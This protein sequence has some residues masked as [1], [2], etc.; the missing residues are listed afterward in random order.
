[1]SNYPQPKDC[2]D[3][4]PD[5]NSDAEEIFTDDIRNN[6]NGLAGYIGSVSVS[7]QGCS[8]GLGQYYNDSNRRK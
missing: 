5:V 6:C 1:M 7:Y 8:S 4:N 2:D 3:S